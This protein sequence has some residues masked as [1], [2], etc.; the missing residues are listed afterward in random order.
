MVLVAIQVLVLGLYRPPVFPPPFPPQT[1]ISSAGPHSRVKR[2]PRGRVAGAGRCPGI[3]SGIVSPTGVQ[4]AGEPV[5]APGYHFVA[6]PDGRVKLASN[7]RIGGAGCRPTI[8]AWVVPPASVEVIGR[9]STIISTSPDNPFH[10]QS[11]PP[12]DL[13]VQRA[14]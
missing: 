2:S 3:S 8:G 14:R 10:C 4:K 12:C 1:I 6:G 7:G 5:A 13:V 9:A 11:T